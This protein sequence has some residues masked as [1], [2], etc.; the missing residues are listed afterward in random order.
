[1]PAPEQIELLS[2]VGIS[3]YFDASPQPA[4]NDI[5]FSVY[6]GDCIVLSGANGSGKTVLMTIIAG[7]EKPSSGSVILRKQEGDTRIGLV[8]QDAD[9]QILGDT[10]EEDILFGIRNNRLPS[11]LITEKLEAVLNLTGLTGK[12]RLPARTLSGGEKRRLAAAGVL[13]MDCDI[14]I[15]DEPFANLDFAGV[16]QVTALIERL[17]AQKKTLIIITHELEKILAAA[18]R[19]MILHEGRLVYDALPEDALYTGI[20][21][22]YGIKNPLCSYRQLADLIWKTD[23]AR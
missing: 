3:K 21:E 19:L 17:L 23:N 6:E 1:M 14:I 4:L 8:F 10:V 7:L 20:L 12:N 13:M 16:T 5:S 11:A 18:N 15:F 9:A 2:I 22:Q